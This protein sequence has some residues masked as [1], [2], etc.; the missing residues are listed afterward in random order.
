MM[1]IAHVSATFLPIVGGVEWKVHY[2]SQEYAQ[3]GHR[4]TVFTLRLPSGIPETALPSA[5]L[6]DVVRCG[7]PFRGA[8]RLGLNSWLLARAITSAHRREPFDVIHCHQLGPMAACSAN[9]R[10]K[11]GLPVVVTTSGDD[12]NTI[13]AAGYG[14]RCAPR[15][16]RMVRANV[17]RVDV[18]GSVSRGIRAELEAIGTTAR[19]VNIPNGVSWEEFQTGPSRLFRDK[20]RLGDDTVVV[21]SVGR[22]F[23]LKRYDLGI[24]AFAR[25]ITGTDRSAPGDRSSRVKAHYVLIGRELDS[26]RPLV[27]R[28][29]V[30][31]HVSFINQMP[32]SELPAAYHSADIFF[33]PSESEGFAQVNAQ[34]LACGLPLVVTDAPGNVDAADHGGALVARCNDVASMAQCLQSL[35]SNPDIRRELGAAAHRASRHYAWSHIAEQYLEVFESLRSARSLG[36]NPNT[37]RQASMRSGAD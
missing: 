13:P 5:P 26:L 1:R 24:E 27:D 6:Y 23:S 22:N 25:V 9:V 31:S 29:G 12:V 34:A 28:L 37:T 17:R 11:T 30:S 20:L 33:N 4:V 36:A 2:L 35:I 7:F 32:I 14:I 18:V 10:Q 19:I 16:D 21:L 15:L 8:G 3:R